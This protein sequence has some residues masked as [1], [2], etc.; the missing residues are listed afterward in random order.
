MKGIQISDDFVSQIFGRSAGKLSESTVE[1]ESQDEVL[2]EGT[3]VCPLCDSELNEAISEERIQEH[4]DF[5]LSVIN[6][7]FDF[8]GDD[9]DESELE[10]VD[11]EGD[12]EDV[13][14]MCGPK[15]KKM[16]PKKSG[17]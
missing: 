14:E 1:V 4:I 9:L 7:N 17:K 8:E 13:D 5:F 15:S 2:E 16:K 12:G 10:E 6:E 11:E 3:H